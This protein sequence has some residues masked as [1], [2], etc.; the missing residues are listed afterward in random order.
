MIPDETKIKL[1]NEIEKNGNVSLSCAK[2]DVNKATFYRWMKNK[3][4]KKKADEAL[5]RG[6]EANC[7]LAE[8]ALM[9][10]VKDKKLEAIKYVLGHNS[11]RYKSKVYRF[12]HQKIVPE[13]THEPN[14]LNDFIKE[15]YKKIEEEKRLKMKENEN[16]ENN[17]IKK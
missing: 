3:S 1:L 2:V 4:F 17:E 13:E 5:M 12:I 8:S 6:R 10:L 9:L 15:A 14:N 11:P 7:D 16:S